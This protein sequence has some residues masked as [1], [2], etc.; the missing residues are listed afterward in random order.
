MDDPEAAIELSPI[1]AAARDLLQGLATERRYH[2]D[3]ARDLERQ[4]SDPGDGAEA[5]LTLR[6]AHAAMALGRALEFLLDP[7][8]VGR[9]PDVVEMGLHLGLKDLFDALRDLEAGRDPE[10]LRTHGKTKGASPVEASFKGRCAAIVELLYRAGDE[11]PQAAQRLA[12]GL[13]KFKLRTSG[14]GGGGP[15]TAATVLQWRKEARNARRHPETARTY[16]RVI[17]SASAR[18]LSRQQLRQM[19]AGLAAGEVQDRDTLTFLRIR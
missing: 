18:A 13:A 16:D 6:R 2:H 4:S 14:G 11:L 5:R 7:R 8:V 3:A 17:A 12:D 19:A 15:I 1:E 10:L 9:F